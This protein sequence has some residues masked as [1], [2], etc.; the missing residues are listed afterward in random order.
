MHLFKKIYSRLYPFAAYNLLLFGSFILLL[1]FR[2]GLY[3]TGF[4]TG[5]FVLC[6]AYLFTGTG[7]YFFNDLMD[8]STDHKAG[9]FNS[10]QVMNK[11]VIILLILFLWLAGYLLVDRV[12]SGLR[13]F[14]VLQ[15]LLLV[16]Y[17]L[18]A[19]RLKEKGLLGLVTDACYAHVM[20][21][22]MLLFLVNDFIVLQPAFAINL[23]VL[24]FCIGM[25]D[26][27]IHQVHDL[28]NDK[29]SGVQTFAVGNQHVVKKLVLLFEVF[30][31][32]SILALNIN[33]Y[34]YTGEPAY[35]MM[36]IGLMVY[37]TCFYL[38][39]KHNV[40]NDNV[41]LRGYIIISALVWL[42]FILF[43]HWYWLLVFIVHPYFI[44]FLNQTFNKVWLSIKYIFKIWIGNLVLR[45]IPLVVNT[46]L[47]YL[48]LALGKDLKK[49][50]LYRKENEFGFIKKIRSIF[51]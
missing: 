16:L 2:F 6:L 51:Q 19:I 49:T 5:A 9:K 27:L 47:Y 32:F 20:P 44:S 37:Y 10:T 15:L 23:V 25:R 36:L 7:A 33:M 1:T 43:H 8:V 39:K 46:I 11:G 48:F 21:V 42:G 14:F 38:Q 45:F 18:P 12:L 26:I 40:L 3:N 13:V 22:I 50:P 35:F 41:S 31:V 4:P 24:T 34:S 29:R 17:S 30:I 28:A